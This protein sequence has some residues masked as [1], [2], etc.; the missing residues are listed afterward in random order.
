[1]KRTLVAVAVILT[2]AG[3]SSTHRTVTP[4][5]LGIG[6]PASTVPP[7]ATVAGW[8]AKW[9]TVQPGD[10]VAHLKEVMGEPTSELASRQ[11]SWD[12]GEWAFYAFYSASNP[13]VIQQL[14]IN[15]IS[16]S[17]AQKASLPCSDTRK[18]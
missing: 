4:V 8:A 16:L 17:A 18:A 13:D 15:T 14:D 6:A 3:C 9:C 2:I 5:G 12:A 1:M 11:A 7:A 10:T